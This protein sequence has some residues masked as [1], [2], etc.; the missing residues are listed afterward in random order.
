MLKDGKYEAQ[1]DDKNRRSSLFE[2]NGTTYSADDNGIKKDYEIIMLNNCSFELKDS[3]KVDEIKLTAF[4]KV[5]SKQRRSF[6]IIKIEGNVYY[7]V[8]RVNLHVEC[9][10]GR[11][12]KKEH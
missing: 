4:Q 12:I 8:C 7:F 3:E 1:Y 9:G 6:D 10:A 11:F 5:I 2:I